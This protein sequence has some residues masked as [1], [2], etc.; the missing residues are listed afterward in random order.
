MVSAGGLKLTPEATRSALY[1]DREVARAVTGQFRMSGNDS[2]INLTVQLRPGLNPSVQMAAPLARRLGKGVEVT[3]L[4]Y[5]D[6]PHGMEVDYERKF[7][8]I[9]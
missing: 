4:P 8:H 3:L 6:Y 5:R 7:R 9:S 2:R 1:A